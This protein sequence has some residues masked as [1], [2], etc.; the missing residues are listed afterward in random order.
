VLWLHTVI[1][2]AEAK[3]LIRGDIKA[4]SEDEL[5]PQLRALV[6]QLLAALPKT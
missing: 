3:V 4:K 5:M 2:V 6:R 1:H